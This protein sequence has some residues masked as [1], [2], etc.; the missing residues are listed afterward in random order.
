M[1][2]QSFNMPID[3]EFAYTVGEF[4]GEFRVISEGVFRGE[5]IQGE[6]S[7]GVFMGIVFQMRIFLIPPLQQSNTEFI[8]VM[9]CSLGTPM[10]YKERLQMT[11]VYWVLTMHMYIYDFEWIANNSNV[12]YP[13][14]RSEYLFK[15]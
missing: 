6:N 9:L 1:L 4:S 10:S 13:T 3:F 14:F 8:Y 5:I 2:G 7:R 15:H 12:L 11:V